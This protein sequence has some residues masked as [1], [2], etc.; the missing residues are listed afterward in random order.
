MDLPV[1]FEGTED[2]TALLS[3]AS[4]SHQ[5]F[6]YPKTS[7]REMIDIVATWIKNDGDTDDKPTHFQQREGKY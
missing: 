7:V 2:E 4:K 6:G 5:L 3:N 1:T